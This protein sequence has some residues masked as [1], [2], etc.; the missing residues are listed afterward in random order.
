MFD[1]ARFFDGGATVVIDEGGIVGVEPVR[2]VA[3]PAIIA[4]SV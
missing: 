1:G 4:R 3:P 2:L